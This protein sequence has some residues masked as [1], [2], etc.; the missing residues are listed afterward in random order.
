M[1]NISIGGRYY[2][3]VFGGTIAAP[4]WGLIMNDVTAGMPAENFP[5]PSNKVLY[6]DLIGIPSVIGRSVPDAI[7]ILRSAGFDAI[8]GGETQS[9]LPKGVVA[10]TAPVGLAARGSTIVLLTSNGYVPPP[11]KPTTSSTS[12]SNSPTSPG[13]TPTKPTNTP[14]P[15]GTFT[16][17]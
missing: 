15:T 10:Q 9:T 4:L 7:A 11:P 16:R 8:Q 13:N 1:D 12:P 17:Q 3:N 2:G 14:R 5:A 6:G